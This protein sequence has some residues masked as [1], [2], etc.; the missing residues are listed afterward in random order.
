VERA[1]HLAPV[2]AAPAFAALSAGRRPRQIVSLIPPP[3][4]TA[5]ADYGCEDV[6]L[7]GPGK[8]PDQSLKGEAMTIYQHIRHPRIAARRA[9]RPVKVADFLPRGTAVN[10]FNTR[11]ALLITQAVGSMWCAYAFALFDLI[12]L[13]TAI[14]GG[15]SAIVSWVAQTFLQLVLLSVIMVGQNVQA[16]AADKRAEATFHDASATLHE[17]AHVQGHLAAQDVL[18]TRISEKL[19]L[20]PVPVIDAS[21]DEDIS[22]QD[23]ED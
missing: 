17:V 3:P 23:P 2:A 6:W 12:S 14:R 21:S 19:G 1:R 5:I 10:R 20:D 16:A 22:G 13:P 8:A 15:S 18:L 7:S 4:A 9:D 11:V